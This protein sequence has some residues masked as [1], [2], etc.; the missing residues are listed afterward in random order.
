MPKHVSVFWADMREHL[1]M[2]RSY[3]SM[4]SPEEHAR[5]NKYREKWDR[6]GFIV[7]RG[8]LRQQLAT[9]LGCAASSLPITYSESRRP[10]ILNLN[11][12]FSVSQSHDI[13][14][15]A[16][17]QRG[18]VGCDVEQLDRRLATQAMAERIFTADQVRLL[19]ELPPDRWIEG[20]YRNWTHL[21][22]RLKA[23]GSGFLTDYIGEEKPSNF[24]AHH[25][26]PRAN[27]FACVITQEL[28]RQS[29]QREG[30]TARR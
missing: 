15:F 1:P 27:Y 12:Q 6:N 16:I 20:F 8:I 13:A 19:S 25:F 23:L 26:S 18:A 21:E 29:E 28:T 24:V 2:L 7:R 5:A 17:A 10:V 30:P 9:L 11:V 22:A 14:L 3:L 4:L